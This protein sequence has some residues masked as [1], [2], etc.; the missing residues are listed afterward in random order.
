MRIGKF[1][2]APADRKRYVV[3]YLDWLNETE[4]LLSVTMQGNVPEDAFYV[5]G[6]VINNNKEVIFYV[7][8]GLSGV[9]YEV[10][11]KVTTSMQQTKEDTITFAVL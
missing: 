2:K 10:S 5:D 8:G 1:R 4:N 3:N 9:S 6:Y 11:I 7:S